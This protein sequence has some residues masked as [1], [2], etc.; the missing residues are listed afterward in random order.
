MAADGTLYFATMIIDLKTAEGV[1]ITIGISHDIGKTSQWTTLSKKRF[2]DRP[3]VAVASDGA[4][5][6][7][8]NDGA[9]CATQ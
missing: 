5:H 1:Q 8:W 3:W 6:V 2:D 9:V 7:I 4:A